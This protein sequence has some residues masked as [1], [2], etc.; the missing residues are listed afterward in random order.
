MKPFT[1][2]SLV[3]LVAFSSASLNACSRV[4]PERSLYDRLGGNPVLAAVVDE[5]IDNVSQNPKTSRSFDGVKLPVLKESIVSQLCS[6]TGGGCQ[7]EGETMENAHADAKITNAEF[8]LM[9]DAMR[10]ALDHQHVGTREKNE[11][12]KILAPM[13]RDIVAH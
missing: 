12:L 9:V 5:T 8:E 11:L 4:K 2:A 6:L 10:T 13:K 1:T 3:F 7:Y